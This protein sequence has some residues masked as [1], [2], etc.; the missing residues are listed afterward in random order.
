MQLT[1]IQKKEIE[2]SVWIVNTALKRQG[3]SCNKDLRQS[4][5]LYMCECLMR[6]DPSKNIKWTTY[7]YKNV[8]LFIKRTHKKECLKCNMEIGDDVVNID[9]TADP[10]GYGENIL[11]AQNIF[12]L[13]TP[14]ERKILQLKMEGY[15]HEE[16]S[17]ILRCSI[18]KINSYMKSIKGK[19]KGMGYER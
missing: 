7:A 5:I 3:L 16:I 2:N 9:T 18:S 10:V 12:N 6:F 1:A 4:A 13:C 17:V 14:Y 11:L 8:Y 15:K 19:T